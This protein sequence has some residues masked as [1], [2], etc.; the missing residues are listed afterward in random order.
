MLRFV[1][2]CIL[3]FSIP[4]FVQAARDV[5]ACG[6]YLQPQ[7]CAQVRALDYASQCEA[8]HPFE[9]KKTIAEDQ[10]YAVY[11]GDSIMRGTFASLVVTLGAAAVSWRDVFS[12][13]LAWYHKDQYFCCTSLSASNPQ[14][15][16]GRRGLEFNTTAHEA[17]ALNFERGAR[18]CAIFVWSPS[19]PSVDL[20]Q[21]RIKPSVRPDLIIVNQGLHHLKFGKLHTKDVARNLVENTYAFLEKL[22]LRVQ[23]RP[24]PWI[25]F[26]ETTSVVD[27]VIQARYPS[28]AN[29]FNNAR[30]SQYNLYLREA[31]TRTYC[32][33][34]KK[35]TLAQ[36]KG[37]TVKSGY[38]HAYSMTANAP[39]EQR[40]VDGVHLNREFYM[41]LNYLYFE[42]GLRRGAAP[43][44]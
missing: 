28:Y 44:C 43:S 31:V 20:L 3:A 26:Q 7:A 30:I 15:V 14:C 18:F 13:D 10:F 1:L 38:I 6:C 5:T 2:V 11:A 19:D 24:P 33:H 39:R 16:W 37:S 8:A 36:L 17:A 32:N 4:L 9:L 21:L 27:T 22:P 25:I 42:L 34:I 40:K 41:K 12:F 29:R 23:G 35:R